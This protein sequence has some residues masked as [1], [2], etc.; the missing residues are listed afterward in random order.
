MLVAD[1]MPFQH[2]KAEG[3]LMPH[4]LGAITGQRSELYTQPR[5]WHK[6]RD[7]ERGEQEAL[8]E[9]RLP[10]RHGREQSLQEP[11]PPHKTKRKNQQTP[12]PQNKR[13]ETNIP[14]KGQ[15][16]RSNSGWLAS[17]EKSVGQGGINI[18]QA[19]HLP[20]R[21]DKLERRGGR[22][23]RLCSMRIGIGDLA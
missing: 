20:Q 14:A 23:F 10:A 13:V 21:I 22:D 18:L 1:S 12:Q 2:C 5:K 6:C 15:A 3:G 17:A 9:E 11:P 16:G 19:Q 7:H 8:T 4:T